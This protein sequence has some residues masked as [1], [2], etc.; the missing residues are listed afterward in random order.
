VFWGWFVL[1]AQLGIFGYSALLFATLMLGYEHVLV[2]R[3]FTK[4]DRAFFTINGYLGFVFF[5]C[6][7]LDKVFV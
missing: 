7:V 4:I 5:G 1:A 2:R 3:D 6:V